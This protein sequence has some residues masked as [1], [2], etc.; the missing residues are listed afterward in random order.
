M[1]AK[2]RRLN[3]REVRGVLKNGRSARV[4][5]VVARY[6]IAQSSKAAVVVSGKVAKRAVDRNRIRRK[7]YAALA[8]LPKS[9]HLVFFIQKKEF[10]PHDI[11]LICLKLS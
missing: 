5:T 9:K 1:L 7:G 11:T 8:T 10:D 6:T 3:A 4:G 2:L